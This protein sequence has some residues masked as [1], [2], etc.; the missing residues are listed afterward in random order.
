MRGELLRAVADD[1]R[2]HGQRLDVVDEGGLAPQAG[3]RG[4]RRAQARHAAAAFDRGDQ[5]RL[6]AADEGAGAFLDGD[7]QRVIAPQ[8]IDRRASRAAR[9]S[10]SAAFTRRKASGYSWRM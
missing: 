3:L 7:A 6:F 2:H 4:E 9:T 5:G 8:Q 1:P 10:A